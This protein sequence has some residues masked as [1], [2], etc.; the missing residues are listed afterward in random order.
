[1]EEYQRIKNKRGGKTNTVFTPEL[2]YKLRGIY[3]KHNSKLNCDNMQVKRKNTS[4]ECNSKKQ[5][6]S[7]PASEVVQTPPVVTPKWK[8][9][10]DNTLEFVGEMNSGSHGGL[11]HLYNE[12][13]CD[14]ETEAMPL[15]ADALHELLMGLVA[16]STYAELRVLMHKIVDCKDEDEDLAK[17]DIKAEGDVEKEDNLPEPKQKLDVGTMES[18]GKKYPCG[19]SCV[20]GSPDDRTNR[21]SADFVYHN[22]SRAMEFLLEDGLRSE[23]ACNADWCVGRCFYVCSGCAVDVEDERANVGELLVCEEQMTC[24]RCATVAT[25]DPEDHQ[26]LCPVCDAEDE[27]ED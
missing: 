11:G 7:Q 5:K 26:V 3:P 8:Q 18:T 22:T 6:V 13:V 27:E 1:M 15:D 25:W 19:G 20:L 10:L 12:C 2:N 4:E 24:C 21:T 17:N 16:N 23:C 14:E 9:I